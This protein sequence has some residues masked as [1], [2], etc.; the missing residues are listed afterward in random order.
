MEV[1]I[2]TYGCSA[3]K[4][5]TEIIKGKLVG[6]GINLT[7]NPDI[8]EII[9]LNTCIVKG[10]TEN[11]IKRRVSDLSNLNKPIIIAGC[12]PQIRKFNP[13]IYCLGT[14]HTKEI[15]NLIRHIENKTY[16]PE[17]F[18]STKKEIKLNTQK[19]NQNKKIG[20]TQI[21]EG[22]FGSCTFCITK[23]AKGSLHSYPKDEIITNINSDLKNGCKEIWITSQDNAA[24]NNDNK[25]HSLPELLSQITKL[26][27][28]FK[29]RI[30]MM[31][32]NNVLP[33]MNQLIE[34][35]KS[36][37]IYKFLH[38]PLQS[39]SDKI[40]KSMNRNY[41][42][43]DFLKIIKK[44][45]SN[46]QDLSISTDVIVGFP[47]ETEKDFQET[48]KLLK[49]IKPEIL[50]IS[51]Y[52]QRD[53]TPAAKLVQI[54]EKIKK[55]RAT[56]LMKLHLN[57]AKQNKE[58]LLNQEVEVLVNEQH[59]KNNYKSRDGNYNLIII[60]SDKNLLGKVV[61][62]KITRIL[63]HYCYAKLV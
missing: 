31:N 15:L 14:H 11:K 43:N 25:K 3:N 42:S 57:I 50:N 6:A 47:G 5:N 62:V 61:K 58:K 24:Y 56:E 49:E 16:F 36:N 9:I 59:L 8:A 2:E 12:M 38:L 41:T 10:P 37:K 27:F 23:L 45:K 21:S 33:I 35:Y 46:F 54:D 44:F 60:K 29:L 53:K 13:P 26:P 4:N 34:V 7:T 63:P 51:R 48:K 17:E 1:Y 22:C 40:L 20:I 39:A 55:Q 19:I 52:W 28:K 18:T 30:G 32:P